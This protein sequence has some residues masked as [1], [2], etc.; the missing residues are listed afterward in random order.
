MLLK[1]AIHITYE[2]LETSHVIDSGYEAI[3]DIT[4]ARA[5]MPAIITKIY[6]TESGH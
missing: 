3:N 1:Y 4:L 5:E 6:L 2:G